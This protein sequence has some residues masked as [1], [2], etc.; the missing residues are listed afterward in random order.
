MC[1]ASLSPATQS[2]SSHSAAKGWDV[3]GG[4]AN[5]RPV[6][7]KPAPQ[8]TEQSQTAIDTR[9]KP[10]PVRRRARRKRRHPAQFDGLR[11]GGG[12]TRRAMPGHQLPARPAPG[13]SN[14][15]LWSSCSSGGQRD[16]P[17][18]APVWRGAVL[19]RGRRSSGRP[20]GCAARC[21]GWPRK[22]SSRRPC[23]TARGH[24]APTTG[25][26][27]W[28]AGIK[29]AALNSRPGA[30]AHRGAERDGTPPRPGIC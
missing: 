27:G 22:A 23:S 16:A 1:G 12:G 18:P 14:R 2:T 4:S 21:G 13:P 15:S 3:I 29:A 26:S 28:F 25:W 5:R 17:G 20:T 30:S 8:P 9:R 7:R 24:H 19:T 10:M 11:R 6:R